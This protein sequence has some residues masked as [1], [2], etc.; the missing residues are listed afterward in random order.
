[1]QNILCMC[2]YICGLEFLYI[3]LYIYVCVLKYA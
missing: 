3:G 1:M 2:V